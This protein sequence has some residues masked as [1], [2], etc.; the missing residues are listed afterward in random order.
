MCRTVETA[1]Q[2]FVTYKVDNRLMHEMDTQGRTNDVAAAD[3]KAVLDDIAQTESNVAIITHLGLIMRATGLHLSE[4]EMAVMRRNAK[5]QLILLKQ[6]MGSDLG[7]HARET[8][9]PVRP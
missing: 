7:P 6:I 1:R 3:L 2:M 9:G 4:G 5:G 8:L